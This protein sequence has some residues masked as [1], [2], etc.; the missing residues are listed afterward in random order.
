MAFV[1]EILIAPGSFIVVIHFVV[2]VCW[3]SWTNIKAQVYFLTVRM[4]ALFVHFWLTTAVWMSWQV[5]VMYYAWRKW[6]YTVSRV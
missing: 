6:G 3:R 5:Y 1:E 2:P 4:V